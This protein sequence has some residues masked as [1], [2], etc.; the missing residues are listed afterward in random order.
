MI[1]I[2]IIRVCLADDPLHK[3]V[4]DSVWLFFWQGIEGSVAIIMVS[5]TAY[6][7]LFGSE[8]GSSPKPSKAVRE[9]PRSYDKM[10]NSLDR[11]DGSLVTRPDKSFSGVKTLVRHVPWIKGEGIS[12]GRNGV[13]DSL[14]RGEIPMN[15]NRIRVTHELT[16]HDVRSSSSSSS[17]SHVS[18]ATA[19]TATTRNRRHKCLHPN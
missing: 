9:I 12:K 3:E 16:L 1:L 17:S 2:A 10:G 19:A 18:V 15:N 6:R 4:I 14:D 11:Y 8:R 7:G 13:R 5:L